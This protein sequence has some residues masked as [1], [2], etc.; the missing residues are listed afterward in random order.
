MTNLLHK[1]VPRS[2]ALDLCYTPTSWL[3]TQNFLNQYQTIR[4]RRRHRI[5]YA[6]Y[7]IFSA[8]QLSLA[9]PQPTRKYENS[10]CKIKNLVILYFL[11]P[12]PMMSACL[13]GLPTYN[14]F[15]ANPRLNSTSSFS[16][17]LPPLIPVCT[18][19]TNSLFSIIS[20]SVILPP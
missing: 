15:Y 3:L 14:D 11:A 4:C 18:I 16:I 6:I 8:L 1:T 9:L 17:Y 10:N 5:S 20:G 2:L 19:Q 13:A 12:L 7:D